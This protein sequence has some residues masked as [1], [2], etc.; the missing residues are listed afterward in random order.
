MEILESRQT[1]SAERFLIISSTEWTAVGLVARFKIG[2]N[3]G[4]ERS[5][6]AS[7]SRGGS[8]LFSGIHHI[9]SIFKNHLVPFRRQQWFWH[10][11]DLL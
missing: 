6:L 7:V 3:K 5:W 10:P 8:C 4:S 11:Q 2:A 9:V 1:G